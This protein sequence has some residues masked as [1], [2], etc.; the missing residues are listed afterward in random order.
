M[1]TRVLFLGRFG[2]ARPSRQLGCSRDRRFLDPSG[3]RP[4]LSRKVA[5]AEA[6]FFPTRGDPAKWEVKATETIRPNPWKRRKN[7]DLVDE[8]LR[9]LR[10]LKCTVYTVS[11]NKKRMNHP[12]ALETTAPLQMQALVEHF[13]VECARHDETGLIVSDWSSYRLDA[14]VSQCVASFGPRAYRGRCLSVRLV[15]DSRMQPKYRGNGTPERTGSLSFV[16]HAVP[17][18]RGH[19]HLVETDSGTV[20]PATRHRRCA[21]SAPTGEGVWGCSSRGRRPPASCTPTPAATGRSWCCCTG[22]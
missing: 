9:I 20:T 13:A 1:S 4:A 8:T 15:G 17:D 3:E 22:C 5:G 2:Q 11:I 16:R 19:L 12:M 6:H 21:V 7:R 18:R 14:H 10:L